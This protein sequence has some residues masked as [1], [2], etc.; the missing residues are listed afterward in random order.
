MFWVGEPWVYVDECLGFGYH[1]FMILTNIRVWEPWVH[2]FDEC[3]WL[4][5]HGFVILMNVRVWE[6][7]FIVLT[8]VFGC[9]EP[10]VYDFDECLG[11][12]N[13]GFMIL[14]NVSGLG[15]MGFRF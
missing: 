10:W 15:T 3:F 7:W 8:N 2:D 4:G 6:P 1:G 5:N 11:F 9:W 12:G 14:M 13:H